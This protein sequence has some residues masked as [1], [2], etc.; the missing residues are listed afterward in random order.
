MGNIEILT[1]DEVMREYKISR[2]FIQVHR[3]EMGGRGKP[4]RFE[5]SI[6]ES[7]FRRYFH[8][9]IESKLQTEADARTCVME[10]EREISKFVEHIRETKV[11]QIQGKFR[12]K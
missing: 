2:H 5:R 10:I 6:V 4:L 9:E 3:V 8:E 12:K 7:F 11:G 1:T